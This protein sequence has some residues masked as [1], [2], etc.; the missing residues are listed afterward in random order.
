LATGSNKLLKTIVW[1]WV[2]KF[3][4]EAV[5]VEEN[6]LGVAEKK[7]LASL[8]LTLSTRCITRSFPVWA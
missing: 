4:L 1:Q 5:E 2:D 7:L 3:C 6:P 8:G